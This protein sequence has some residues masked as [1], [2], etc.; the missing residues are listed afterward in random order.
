MGRGMSFQPIPGT[1]SCRAPRGLQ[2]RNPQQV[3]RSSRQVGSD[4]GF[5]L[6]DEA[7]LS[8]SVYRL[9]PA[10]DLLH[11]LSFA[12]ADLV[13]LGA[14]GPPVEPWCLASFNA[15]NVRP[16]VVFTKSFTW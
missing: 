3:M 4:L 8:H 7:G 16:D 6:S 2:F 11:P 1:A 12:L 5:G 15:R 10:E 14:G 13:A 9:Q